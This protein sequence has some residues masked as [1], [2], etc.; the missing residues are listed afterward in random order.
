[1]PTKASVRVVSARGHGP[2]ALF[3]HEMAWV[4]VW[5]EGGGHAE[6]SRRPPGRA[7]PEWNETVQVSG[8]PGLPLHLK[9][10]GCMA[11]HEGVDE[12]G[13]G[14]CALAE[15][16]ATVPLT[17]SNGKEAGEVVVEIILE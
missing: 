4:E 5:T 3:P 17:A 1:M 11:G 13:A 10:R 8:E 16:P 9:M 12:I 2:N 7:A 6:T 14:E 15:G